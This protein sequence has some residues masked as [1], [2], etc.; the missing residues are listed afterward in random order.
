MKQWGKILLSC[1]I[2]LGSAASG[3]VLPSANAASASQVKIM[4][5]NYPLPFPVEPVVISGTTMVPFRAISEALGINV[6]WNQKA[7]KITAS[8][9]SDGIK[10]TVE[11]TLGSKTAKVNGQN[12]ALTLAPRT[13]NNTTMI[14]LSFF[15]QQFGAGVGWNQASKTVFII[16]PREEMYTLG[17]Y[18]LRS[19]DEISYLHHFDAAAFGWSRI[20]REGNFTLTGD[21]YRWPAPSGEITGE[22][23]IKDVASEG[24]TPYLMVYSVDGMLELTKNLED[25][26]LRNKTIDS[27]MEAAAEKGFKGIALD[28]EG[29][30]MTGDKSKVKSDYNTFVK[31]LSSRAKQQDMKLTVIVHALNSVYQGYDYKTLANL[32]DDL[33]LMAYAYGDEQSPEPVAKVDEAIQLALKQVDKDKL[34]LGIS[35]GSETSASINTKIGLAK[36][37][38]LKGIALWRLGI[39]GPDTWTEMNKTIVL[40]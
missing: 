25:K 8:K 16:S 34:I 7:K 21:E 18:A 10:K 3:T 17:Y 11:L 6:I 38:D 12:A 15:S 23:I 13:I 29:L 32:A 26:E 36:R 14:P 40:D 33:V 27:I 4:L 5:D 31:E 19:F 28:L 39:I 20:D 2:V 9:L 30:G 37:Y 1:A 35:R 24:T 22:S